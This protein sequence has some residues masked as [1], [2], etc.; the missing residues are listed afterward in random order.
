MS[1]APALLAL[2]KS[3]PPRSLYEIILPN[4]LLVKAI[5]NSDEIV[6]LF[7]LD[8]TL[9][10]QAGTKRLAYLANSLH[11]LDSSLGGKL[12][13]VVGD[14]VGDIKPFN[15]RLRQIFGLPAWKMQ[16]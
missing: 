6:P 3:N 15:P 10:K 4:K 5:S 14:H 9:I 1:K 11:E 13:V 8:P 7:I 2:A 16:P 12:H